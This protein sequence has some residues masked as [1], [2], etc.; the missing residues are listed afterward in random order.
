MHRVILSG[1]IALYANRQNETMHNYV[2]SDYCNWPFRLRHGEYVV[3]ISVIGN[4]SLAAG[5]GRE[6]AVNAGREI[7]V[8]GQ[9][10]EIDDVGQG[11]TIGENTGRGRGHVHENACSGKINIGVVLMMKSDM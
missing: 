4:R 2:V 10:R 5:R 11:H 7:A 3:M 1:C 6:N 9:G 8:V